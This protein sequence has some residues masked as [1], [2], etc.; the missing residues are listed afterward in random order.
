MYFV[1]ITNAR[2]IIIDFICAHSFYFLHDLN[3]FWLEALLNV[4]LAQQWW[5]ANHEFVHSIQ[6]WDGYSELT[7][8]NIEKSDRDLKRSE[9][10]KNVPEFWS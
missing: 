8:I 1:T 5:Y 10:D 4:N 3:M 9:L 7:F 6:I 2:N